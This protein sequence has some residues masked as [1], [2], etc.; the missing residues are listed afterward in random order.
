MLFGES[1]ERLAGD[2]SIRVLHVALL[3]DLAEH[4]VVG[5][6]DN[7][8]IRVHVLDAGD[9]LVV[10]VLELLVVKVLDVCVVDADGKNH[11]VGLVVGELLFE[12]RADLFKIV[13]NLGSVDSHAR[14]SDAGGVGFGENAGER[15][16]RTGV[17]F[18]G[19]GNGDGVGDAVFLGD[20]RGIE[21]A[22]GVVDGGFLRHVGAAAGAV[23]GCLV[24]RFFAGEAGGVKNVTFSLEHGVAGDIGLRYRYV[25]RN[26]GGGFDGFRKLGGGCVAIRLFQRILDGA[27]DGILQ[28]GVGNKLRN[29]RLL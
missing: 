6:E 5:L 26:L 22:F 25:V 10:V 24:L 7:R 19:I 8:H 27:G 4:V 16:T 1:E 20:V 29:S 9:E 15:E 28:Q 17:L 21:F 12:Q 23:S 2:V 3:L 11:K 18:H 13:M 14:I